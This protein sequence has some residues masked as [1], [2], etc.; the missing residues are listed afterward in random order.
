[1]RLNSKTTPKD[2]RKPIQQTH[3]V[4]DVLWDVVEILRTHLPRRI[5]RNLLNSTDSSLFWSGIEWNSRK[6]QL[7][8]GGKLAY[9]YA[10]ENIFVSFISFLR[11][12]HW[13]GSEI[14]SDLRFLRSNSICSFVCFFQEKVL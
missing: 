4:F 2:F 12:M 3:G 13:W 14:L 9:E 7:F 1:M 6:F 8:S 10:K 5:K 11:T